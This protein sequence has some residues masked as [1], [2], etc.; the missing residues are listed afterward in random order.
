MKSKTIFLI[1]ITWMISVHLAFSQD[2]ISSDERTK[3]EQQLFDT[4]AWE[5]AEHIHL[6]SLI[7]PKRKKH[8]FSSR[9]S[10]LVLRIDTL[11]MKDRSGL[12]FYG[13][14]QIRLEIGY[15]EIGNRVF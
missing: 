15:A 3:K 10:V 11:I 1:A 13:K 14:K 9:D 8:S 4:T 2:A 7:I 12:R 5:H 6:R